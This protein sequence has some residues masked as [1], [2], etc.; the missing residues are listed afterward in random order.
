[1]TA[2]RLERLMEL[3][4]TYCFNALTFIFI[5]SLMPEPHSALKMITY[6]DHSLLLYAQLFTNQK[7]NV[8]RIMWLIIFI[9]FAFH[10]WPRSPLILSSS[11]SSLKDRISLPPAGEMNSYNRAGAF[12]QCCSPPCLC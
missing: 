7:L 9:S 11:G 4:H 3:F 5:P 10:L 1:M 6:C 2:K 12:K 8:C